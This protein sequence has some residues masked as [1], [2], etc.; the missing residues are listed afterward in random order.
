VHCSLPGHIACGINS[1]E[2]LA[3]NAI[4]SSRPP[5]SK[6]CNALYHRLQWLY[7]AVL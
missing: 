4:P 1:S 7:C 6:Y 5:A 3:S 2:T